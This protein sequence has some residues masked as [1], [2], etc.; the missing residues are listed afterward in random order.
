M[1]TDQQG[2]LPFQ[3]DNRSHFQW[4]CRRHEG[5]PKGRIGLHREAKTCESES[6]QMEAARAVK[7]L[8]LP[9]LV[10]KWTTEMAYPEHKRAES[11]SQGVAGQGRCQGYAIIL[12][13]PRHYLLRMRVEIRCRE[14]RREGQG[15]KR[16]CN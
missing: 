12:S 3:K 1:G 14:H 6:Y 7:P 4:R 16:R 9:G 5:A 15:P 11:S 2:P 13:S 10:S 8:E